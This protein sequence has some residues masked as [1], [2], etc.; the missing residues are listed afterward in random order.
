MPYCPLYIS[1]SRDTKTS[2]TFRGQ[3]K[4]LRLFSGS[5]VL[6]PSYRL[7]QELEVP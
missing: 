6:G 1:M 4:A 2:C 7:W 5:R 3:G